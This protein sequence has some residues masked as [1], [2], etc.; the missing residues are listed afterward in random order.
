MKTGEYDKERLRG[1]SGIRHRKTKD[2]DDIV[3]GKR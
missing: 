1:K 2:T 3:T